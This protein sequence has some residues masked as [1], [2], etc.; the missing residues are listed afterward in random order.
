MQVRE[1][2]ETIDM[3]KRESER[4]DRTLMQVRER[5]ERPLI[6]MREGEERPLMQVRERG[7]TID[8]QE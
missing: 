4:G 7:E 6:Q 5:E 8:T 2:G 3:Q 1:R